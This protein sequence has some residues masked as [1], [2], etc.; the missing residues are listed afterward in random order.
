MGDLLSDLYPWTKSFHVMA[1][2]SWMVGLFYLP[3]LFVY[4]VEEAQ[5]DPTSAAIFEKM[6]MK[7]RRMIMNPAMIATWVLGLMLVFTP[8][9][10]D[11]SWVWP[12]TKAAGVLGMTWFHYWLGKRRQD[13]LTGSNTLT[14]RQFRMMNEVPTLLMALIVISVFLRF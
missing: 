7:L 8:G 9:I 4:H 10:V 1:V 2:I 5:A 6:E 14:G 11:W 12:W 13:F 3:R